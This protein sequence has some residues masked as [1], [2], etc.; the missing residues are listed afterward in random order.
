M[1]ADP[2]VVSVAELAGDYWD[3]V[4]GAVLVALT[5]AQLASGGVPPSAVAWV[6]QSVLGLVALTVVV[7]VAL[8]VPQSAARCRS[9]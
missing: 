1:V 3:A 4:S 6:V 2:A 8:W 5:T 7:S 9:M